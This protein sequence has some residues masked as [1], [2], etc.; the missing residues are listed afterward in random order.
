[1]EN[2]LYSLDFQTALIHL[3]SINEM[4]RKNGEKL[5]SKPQHGKFEKLIVLLNAG[6]FPAELEDFETLGLESFEKDKT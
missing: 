6:K 3:N 5:K 4:Q 1:M 2:S